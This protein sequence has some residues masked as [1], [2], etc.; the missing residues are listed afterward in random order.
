VDE[1]LNALLP[2]LQ[3][4]NMPATKELGIKV[5]IFSPGVP[6]LM[7][8]RKVWS[9]DITDLV[10]SLAGD[11]EMYINS[12]ELQMTF[13]NT[14]FNSKYCSNLVVDPTRLSVGFP[15]SKFKSGKGSIAWIRNISTSLGLSGREVIM[16]AEGQ[17]YHTLWSTRHE[18][19]QPEDSDVDFYQ[20]YNIHDQNELAVKLMLQRGFL[21]LATKFKNSVLQIISQNTLE[22][23]KLTLLDHQNVED[24][25][26]LLDLLALEVEKGRMPQIMVEYF[27]KQ[28]NL[29]VEDEDETTRSDKALEEILNREEESDDEY[30]SLLG[31]LLDSLPSVEARSDHGETSSETSDKKE[32]YSAP[33]SIQSSIR[34]PE[35]VIVSLAHSA[36]MKAPKDFVI[37]FNKAKKRNFQ[38]AYNLMLPVS[39]STTGFTTDSNGSCWQ[40]L[41]SMIDELDELDR[42]WLRE[43]VITSLLNT[44]AVRVALDR[45]MSKKTNIDDDDLD[46]EFV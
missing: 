2:L 38:V 21:V 17:W 36:L 12:Q 10:N 45:R 15:E 11:S 42:V 25:D 24:N 6:Q 26:E 27:H 16:Q 5:N 32:G 19:Q 34:Q 41:F 33:L 18:V 31:E 13:L 44:E 1:R 20:K 40:K 22:T 43:Y 30:G 3:E 7:S 35:G 8:S 37:R 14:L 23:S 28:E 46:F 4:N 29:I 39:I 9:L